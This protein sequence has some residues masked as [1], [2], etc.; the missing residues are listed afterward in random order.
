MEHPR[1]PDGLIGLLGRFPDKP[2]LQARVLHTQELETHV[3][4]LVE[5]TTE[6]GERVQ[7]FLLVPREVDG[8]APAVLAIHQDGGARPY[9]YGKS[10]P[11]GV[12]GDPELAYGR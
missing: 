1:S 7:A 2:P 5:Y 3:R 11:A 9:A 4:R 6:E 8:S 12:G 10:E